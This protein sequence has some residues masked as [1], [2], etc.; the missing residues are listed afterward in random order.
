MGLRATKTRVVNAAEGR[1]APSRALAFDSSLVTRRVPTSRELDPY[2]WN[3]CATCATCTRRTWRALSWL[4]RS[5][6]ADAPGSV[7]S[8]R[9]VP[10]SRFTMRYNLHVALILLSVLSYVV[11]QYRTK[12]VRAPSYIFRA[13]LAAS[14]QYDFGV[15]HLKC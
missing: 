3:T 14:S 1:T 8:T 12:N 5:V 15:R 13:S 11:C 6:A 9:S 4:A 2:S 7:E 10:G